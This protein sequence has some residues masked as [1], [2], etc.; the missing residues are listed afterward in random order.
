MPMEARKEMTKRNSEEMTVQAPE[1][2]IS[3]EELTKLPQPQE[4][5]SKLAD[6]VRRYL[7]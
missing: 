3:H 1:A 7:F 4:E 5:D 6:L 2:T